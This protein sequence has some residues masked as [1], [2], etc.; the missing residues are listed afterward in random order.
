MTIHEIITPYDGSKIYDKKFGSACGLYTNMLVTPER[1]YFPQ[2]GI[3]EDAQ[4]LAQ[5]SHWTTREIIPVLS[6]QVCHMGGGVRCMS[7]QLRGKNA[8]TLRAYTK[9]QAK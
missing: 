6:N 3:A 5:I 7:W 8:Q 9:I 2:F 4:A 1:I